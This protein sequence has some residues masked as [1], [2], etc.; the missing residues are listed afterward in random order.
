[1][2]EIMPRRILTLSLVIL[3]AVACR[4]KEKPTTQAAKTVAEK[5]TNATTKS[6]GP[7]ADTPK[8]D[9]KPPKT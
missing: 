3:F 1:M 8:G 9:I 2:E 4:G 5:S 6:V 7:V